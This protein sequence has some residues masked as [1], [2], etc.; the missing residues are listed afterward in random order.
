MSKQSSEPQVGILMGSASDWGT[1]KSAAD[2]LEELGVAHEAR[3]LSA[4]RTPAETAEYASTAEA[5]GLGVIIAAAGGAAHLAGVVAAH[6]L[7]PVI[8][9]PMQAW[10]LDGL[11]SLLSTVQMPRGIPVAT[12]AIGKAGAVNAAILATQ[13]LATADTALRDTLRRRREAQ[14]AEI[15]RETLE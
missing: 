1:M 3:V 4:H 14:A 12:V 5:R 11:D 8:G 7:L 10:S 13:I 6:T 9:V 2:T 15:L